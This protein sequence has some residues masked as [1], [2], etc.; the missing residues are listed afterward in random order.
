[1]R[2]FLITSPHFKGT[3]EILY[4][5]DGILVRIDVSQTG[6]RAVRLCRK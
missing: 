3:A 5:E 2:K 6:G 4:R 1:M